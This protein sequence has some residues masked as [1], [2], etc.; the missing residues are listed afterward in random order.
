MLI[1]SVR[2]NSLLIILVVSILLRVAAAVFLGNVVVDMPGTNDQISYHSLAQRV[3]A[4]H[5]FSFDRDWWPLTRAGE[6]TAHWSFFY[7][8]YLVVCYALFGINP[9]IARIIQAIIVGALHPYLIYKICHSLFGSKT[10]I[11][12]AALT[13]GY[14]Y[15]IYYSATLM[16]EPFYITTILAAFF[17]CIQMTDSKASRRKKIWL[18]GGLGV[19][20]GVTV[21]L[22][23]LFLVFIPFIFLWVIWTEQR[24]RNVVWLPQILLIILLIGIMILPFSLYNLQRFDQFVLLNTN[25]GYALFFGNHPIYGT[26]FISILTPEMG[27]YQDLIPIELRSLNE[28]ALEKALMKRAVEFIFANPWRVILLSLSRIPIYFQFWPSAGSGA[29]SNLSRIVSFGILWPFMLYGLILSAIK[30]GFHQ[31]SSPAWLLLLF[32]LVYS[33][34]HILSW[35]LIRYRLPLDAILLLYASLAL[36]DL[37]QRLSSRLKLSFQS[38]KS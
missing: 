25:T 6:P 16:T 32:M 12:A 11:L 9:L 18:A 17:I 8:F 21:L 36:I 14:A 4:G 2:A 38:A 29:I 15:F 28:A 10:A 23:Q 7:T 35:T 26:Q 13:A 34:I 24:R 31:L 5:G 27:T 1:K 3:L 20:L 33:G 30:R 19:V 22:R 37:Y